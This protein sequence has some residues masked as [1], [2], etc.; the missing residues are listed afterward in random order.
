[1]S[2][3]KI[4]IIDDDAELCEEL[5]DM[6]TGEGH[7][8]SCASD[9]GKGADIIRNG[10]YD[11][12][13]LDNKMPGVTGIDILKKMKTENINCKVI[14]ISGRPFI[15]K[16]LAEEGLSGMVAG[17]ISKPIDFSILLSKLKSL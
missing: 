1:M 7:V 8:V 4:L 17:V 6:L 16:A 14:M 11:A 2:A 15:E 5:A 13:L 3:K 10:S 9:P 12:V